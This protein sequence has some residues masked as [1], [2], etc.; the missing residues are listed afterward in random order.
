MGM[1]TV[2]LQCLSTSAEMP[3]CSSPKIKHVGV[4]PSRLFKGAFPFSDTATGERP[5][6]AAN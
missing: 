4:V 6:L 5:R 2:V 3:A 1:D